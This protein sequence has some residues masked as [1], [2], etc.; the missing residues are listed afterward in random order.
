MPSVSADSVFFSKHLWV[1]CDAW[2]D[3]GIERSGVAQRS[4]HL[5][6][7][8]RRL[9]PNWLLSVS[10]SVCRPFDSLKGTN[11]LIVIVFFNEISELSPSNSK[12]FGIWIVL[13]VEGLKIPT[14]WRLLF[15]RWANNLLLLHW[16]T[17]TSM[18][19]RF[20]FL[21]HRGSSEDLWWNDTCS[22]LCFSNLRK[23]LTYDCWWK[24]VWGVW[25]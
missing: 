22:A 1:L 9:N 2:L 20:D 10:D 4:C 6:M 23:G 11:W 5:V 13:F 21:V 14:F 16:S 3:S 17:R 8:G 18:R 24:M 7:F 15:P 12:S 19:E 25:N